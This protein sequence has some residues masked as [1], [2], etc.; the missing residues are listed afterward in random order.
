M[1]EYKSNSDKS[2]IAEA[3]P[4]KK[5]EKVIQG[6]VKTKKNKEIKKFTD[7]FISEDVSNVK[8]YILMDV[9]IPAVKK[10]ISDII[11]DGI[12]MLLYGDSD[13]SRRRDRDD[14]RPSYRKYYDDRDNRSR[15]REHE[16]VN[17]YNFD[18]VILNNRGDAEDVLDNMI[19]IIE[20]YGTVSV[21]D[22]YDLVGITGN[23]TD[24]KYGWTDL[25]SAHVERERSGGYIIKLP[26]VLPI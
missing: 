9:L 26:R 2:K 15:S 5:V 21:A 13:R 16:R 12:D 8:S 22:M 19:D 1:E 17:A 6:S 10:A 7:V 4:E 24:N 20:H 14:I 3:V 11:K 18:D 25:R 23:Y